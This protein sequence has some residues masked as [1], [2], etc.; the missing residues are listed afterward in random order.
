MIKGHKKMWF[1][2]TKAAFSKIPDDQ[3]VRHFVG[4]KFPDTSYLSF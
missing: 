4:E 2:P 3:K 1:S